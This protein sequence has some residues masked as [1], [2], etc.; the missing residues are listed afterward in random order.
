[1]SGPSVVLTADRSLMSNFRGNYLFGFLSC[2]PDSRVP[3]VVY[4][5][6]FAPP[7]EAFPDG[8]AKVAPMGLRRVE[9]ALR[10]SGYDRGDVAV[11]HPAH[12]DEV[13]GPETEVVGV[14]AMDPLGR[15][16]VTSSFTTGTD[17][18]PM[19]AVKFRELMGTVGGLD[20]DPSA[21]PGS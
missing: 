8:R 11:A 16:P 3:D 10:E 6:I 18:E 19:N 15:G 7:V 13:V 14:N 2:A 5:R 9:A 4:D 21:A 1:V 20:C 12:L 17:L